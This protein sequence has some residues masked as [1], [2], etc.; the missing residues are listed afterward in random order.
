MTNYS[1]KDKSYTHYNNVLIDGLSNDNP[2][3]NIIGW[4][5]GDIEKHMK[6][7]GIYYTKE[8]LQEFINNYST[9]MQCDQWYKDTEFSS[10]SLGV[11]FCKRCDV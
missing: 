10:F 5:V 8:H 2:F 3:R 1:I 9:C 6:F 11:V 4:H 7:H